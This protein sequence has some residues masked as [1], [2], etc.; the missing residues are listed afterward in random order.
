MLRGLPP[1]GDT[2]CVVAK[3][4]LNRGE[5]GGGQASRKSNHFGGGYH[6]RGLKCFFPTFVFHVFGFYN[7]K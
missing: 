3:G 6:R 2:D 5:G 7:K 4:Q 1:Y